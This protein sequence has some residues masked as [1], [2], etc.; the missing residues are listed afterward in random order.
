VVLCVL[1]CVFLFVCVC[2][3][4]VSINADWTIWEQD[5]EE[6][7]SETE[8]VNTENHIIKKKLY[9]LYSS[10]NKIRVIKLRL[11][12]TCNNVE[13]IKNCAGSIIIWNTWKEERK[14]RELDNTNVDIQ[15]I[16]R[17]RVCWTYLIQGCFKRW[18]LVYQQWNLWCH[19]TERRHA[20]QDFVPFNDLQVC[21]I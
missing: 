4:V 14:L 5:T 21:A 10:S 16:D 9:K 15:D 13:E 11:G 20:S 18:C 17:E 8:Q 2:F 1:M 3:C 7:K 19:G 12:W 6:I